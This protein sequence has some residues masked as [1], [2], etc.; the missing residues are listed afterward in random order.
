MITVGIDLAQKTSHKAAVRLG[1][2]T[3]RRA[4]NVSWAA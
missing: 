2:G 1:D 4:P 3:V